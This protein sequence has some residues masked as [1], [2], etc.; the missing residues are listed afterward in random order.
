MC[1]N[2]CTGPPGYVLVTTGEVD[3]LAARFGL[4][5][6]DFADRYTHL[7]R[8]GLSLNE[9]ET[10]HGH[11]CVFLDRDAIPGKAVCSVYEDRP[12][13]CRS[14]PFWSENVRSPEAWRETGRTCPGVDRGTLHPPQQIRVIRESG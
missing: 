13:Q 14:W 1:G 12:S 9:R 4:S 2:C 5:R 11:D 10:E 6:R 7:T 3:K 8:K